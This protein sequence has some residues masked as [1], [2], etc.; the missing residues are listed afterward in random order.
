MITQ[1]RVK[2]WFKT[3][4]CNLFLPLLNFGVVVGAGVAGAE[5]KSNNHK[6]ISTLVLALSYC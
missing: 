5:K 4:I 2:T 1:S 6:L 3:V